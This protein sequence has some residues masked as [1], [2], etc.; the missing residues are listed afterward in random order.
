MAPTEA[1]ENYDDDDETELEPMLHEDG[2]PYTV[3]EYDR[4]L[5][6]ED[7]DGQSG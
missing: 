6:Q 1:P 5:E 4:L 7:A 3:E 2:T